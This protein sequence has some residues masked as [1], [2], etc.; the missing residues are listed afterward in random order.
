MKFSRPLIR[1]NSRYADEPKIYFKNQIGRKIKIVEERLMDIVSNEILQVEEPNGRTY[2]IKREDLDEF[3][4]ID[5]RE[6]ELEVI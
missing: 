6:Y 2:T 1:A 3:F 5:R 4:A